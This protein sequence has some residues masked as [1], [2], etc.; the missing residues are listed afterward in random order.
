MDEQDEEEEN[1]SEKEEDNDGGRVTIKGREGVFMKRDNMMDKYKLIPEGLKLMVF[2][3]F[4]MNYILATPKQAASLRKKYKTQEE[5]PNS[6]VRIAASNDNRNGGELFL[7]RAIL[8]KNGTFMTMTR[9]PAVVKIPSFTQDHE[10]EYSDLLLYTPWSS[11]ETDLSDALADM[12]VCTTMHEK[13]DVNPEIGPLG[14]PM[15]KIETVRVRLNM[16]A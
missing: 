7:P 13:M 8:L 16:P 2:I 10:K 9:T 1:E 12:V 15:T 11:E 4:V 6:N 14:T 3:Q 5:I